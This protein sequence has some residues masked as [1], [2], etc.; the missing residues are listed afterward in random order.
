MP[1]FLRLRSTVDFRQG[2]E[3]AIIITTFS[4]I[5]Y[6]EGKIVACRA[7]P[8]PKDRNVVIFAQRIAVASR[9]SDI[10]NPMKT[11]STGERERLRI[12]RMGISE[13]VRSMIIYTADEFKRRTKDIAKTEH[14]RDCPPKIDDGLHRPALNIRNRF[15]AR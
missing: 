10:R 7:S 2:S 5:A 12:S 14:T 11:F 9:P 15:P 13:S 6:V 3:H 4:S 8:V 1:S